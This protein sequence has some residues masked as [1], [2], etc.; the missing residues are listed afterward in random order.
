MGR[1]RTAASLRIRRPASRRPYARARAG[2]DL[3]ISYANQLGGHVGN[4][5]AVAV[6]FDVR[7][8]RGEHLIGVPSAPAAR[9]DGDLGQLPA[10][11]LAYL[12]RSD[13]VLLSKPLEQS[14]HDLTLRL[15]RSA[16]GQ[17]E[18]D[19]QQGDSHGRGH[20]WARL[21]GVETGTSELTG[22]GRELVQAC[23]LTA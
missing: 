9:G 6:R 12:C 4:P 8:D 11:E 2:W 23:Y 17:M 20:A 5:R 21:R 15:Q 13:V 10:I 7:Q 14:A 1:A 16:L 18:D 19:L 22:L 3:V